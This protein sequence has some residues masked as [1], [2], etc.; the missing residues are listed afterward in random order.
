MNYI[1]DLW[2]TAHWTVNSGTAVRYGFTGSREYTQRCFCKYNLKKFSL[3]PLSNREKC[4]AW[5]RTRCAGNVIIPCYRHNMIVAIA[6]KSYRIVSKNGIYLFQ[7]TRSHLTIELVAIIVNIPNFF[8]Y[9][10][11]VNEKLSFT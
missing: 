1:I 6:F 10:M 5:L 8:F 9:Y 4:T 2:F 3:I 11:F 7:V